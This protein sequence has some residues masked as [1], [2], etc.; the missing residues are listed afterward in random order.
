MHEVQT[1]RAHS[2]GRHTWRER[3]FV[4]GGI[5]V[6]GAATGIGV[7]VG[8]GEDILATVWLGALGWTVLATVAHALWRG[9]RLGDWSSGQ[10]YEP[11]GVNHDAGDSATCTGAYT[12]RRTIDP[13]FSYWPGNPH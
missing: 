7:P 1:N 3:A 6:A 10:G 13:R 4:F 2:S 12:Y 5:A 11:P 8:A 9:F